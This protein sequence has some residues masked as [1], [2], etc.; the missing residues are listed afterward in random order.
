[1]R[2][3]RVLPDP[4]QQISGTS[5]VRGGWGGVGVLRW[6]G[7]G[8]QVCG[9]GVFKWVGGCQCQCSDISCNSWIVQ[10]TPNNSFNQFPAY[11]D[12]HLM[13]QQQRHIWQDT[14]KHTHTPHSSLPSFPSQNFGTCHIS[15]Y[16]AFLASSL[17]RNKQIVFILQRNEATEAEKNMRILS[18]V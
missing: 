3:W 13:H 8:V 10:E 12:P 7:G 9:W 11:S 14:S 18:Q 2:R 6:V 16:S 17:L 4:Y 15:F 1:M 5:K